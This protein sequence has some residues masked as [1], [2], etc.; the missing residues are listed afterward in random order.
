MTND[1]KFFDAC[2]YVAKKLLSEQ[3]MSTDL[4]F[5]YLKDEYLYK[6]DLEEIRVVTGLLQRLI[7]DRNSKIQVRTTK[8]ENLRFGDRWLE[9][10]LWNGINI[11]YREI[12]RKIAE[13]PD[14]DEYD[15]YSKFF[16]V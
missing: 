12:E 6:N 16:K 10:T 8:L 3:K 2:K 13:Y 11:P 9:S 4:Y 5:Q 7:E 15:I 14:M 1:R